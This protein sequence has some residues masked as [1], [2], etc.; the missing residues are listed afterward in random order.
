MTA[1]KMTR[2]RAKAA[3]KDLKKQG[4]LPKNYPL[5]A[6]YKLFLLQEKGERILA[7]TRAR[8][9]ER[10]AILSELAGEGHDSSFDLDLLQV[11]EDLPLAAQEA[12]L[13]TE[14]VSE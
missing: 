7:Q 13:R 12:E 5:A 2:D 6:F 8:V 9:G 10:E 3:L 1:R 11:T 14:V 4:R